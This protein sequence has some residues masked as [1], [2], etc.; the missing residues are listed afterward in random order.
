MKQVHISFGGYILV[1]GLLLFARYGLDISMPL[2]VAWFPT[3][4]I[5]ILG[6]IMSKSKK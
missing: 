4:A 2:W 5:M 1:Q 6:F 3:I